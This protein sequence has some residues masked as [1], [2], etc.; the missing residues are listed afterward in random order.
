[1]RPCCRNGSAGTLHP[2]RRSR[3]CLPMCICSAWRI[4]TSL[5]PWAIRRVAPP[6]HEQTKRVAPLT[7][8]LLVWTH[9]G[10]PT[11]QAPPGSTGCCSWL[12]RT[13]ATS[14]AIVEVLRD[15]TAWRVTGCIWWLKIETLLPLIR[16]SRDQDLQIRYQISSIPQWIGVDLYQPVP[17]W[18]SRQS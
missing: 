4:G 6:C 7:P 17:E 1:M 14:Y 12:H 3:V 8:V 16:E 10:R 9:P 13:V 15:V 11:G 2:A 5:V 18:T